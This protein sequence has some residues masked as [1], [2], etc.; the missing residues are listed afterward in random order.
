MSKVKRKGEMRLNND[1]VYDEDFTDVYDHEEVLSYYNDSLFDYADYD[2][3]TFSYYLFK[4]PDIIDAS[5]ALDK[6]ISNE[7][8]YMKIRSGLLHVVDIPE[9][10]DWIIKYFGR[11]KLL[12]DDELIKYL[13][14]AFD[15]DIVDAWLKNT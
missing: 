14:E 13:Y 12:N 10:V 15:A 9:C 3:E 7:H 11:E 1:H 8:N 4:Y 6:F 2:A 5:K